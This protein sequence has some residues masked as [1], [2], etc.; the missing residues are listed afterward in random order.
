MREVEELEA[1]N[2]MKSLTRGPMAKLQR[3]PQIAKP[4]TTK[5]PTSPPLRNTLSN[6]PQPSDPPLTSLPPHRSHNPALQHPAAQ[7]RPMAS[8]DKERVDRDRVQATERQCCRVWRRSKRVSG[9]N[10][11]QLIPPK[12]III[13]SSPPS[14][15]QILNIKSHFLFF[16]VISKKDRY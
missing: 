4:T 10:F 13:Y 16:T 7:L 3:P 11:N 2:S 9:P 1:Q 14:L 5:G 6:P 15:N 8:R 12:K